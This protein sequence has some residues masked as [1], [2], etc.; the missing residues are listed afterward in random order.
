MTNLASTPVSVETENLLR[1]KN[2]ET[3]RGDVLKLLV[4]RS[5]IKVIL[6][7][8]ALGVENIFSDSHCAILLVSDDGKQLRV[9]AAPS[10]PDGFAKALDGIGIEIGSGTC[11][12]AA[13]TGNRVVAA[14]IG[15]NPFWEKFRHIAQAAGYASCC[16]DPVF[17]DENQV[18]GTFEIYKSGPGTPDPFEL[19]AIEYATSL[20]SISIERDRTQRE[21]IRHRTHL[22]HL[23]AERSEAVIKL[24]EELR[25]TVRRA[26]RSN[27]AKSNFL[28][29]MSHEI[30]TPLNAIIPVARLLGETDLSEEQS[31]Y[32]RTIQH[33][34][35][36]LLEILNQLLDWSRIENGKINLTEEAFD[37]SK[38][39]EEVCDIY[40]LSAL[41]KGLALSLDIPEAISNRFIGDRARVRQILSNLV[42]N[43]I[44]F[45][46]RGFVEIRCMIVSQSENSASVEFSVID[47]GRGIRPEDQA[48]V[49][50]KFEQTQKGI[51]Q[52]L[53]GTGLGLAI[54]KA[55]AE[56]MHGRIELNSTFGKGSTFTLA[57]E[58]KK[59]TGAGLNKNPAEAK[60]SA[61]QPH[62]T[63]RS[64]LLADDN[65]VNTAIIKTMLARMGH[66]VRIAVNGIAAVDLARTRQFDLIL[67][68]IN[69]PEMDG[70]EAAQIIR[71]FPDPRGNVPIL[72]LTAGL[73][74]DEVRKC[75]EA[76]MN[77]VL[78]K[79]I[80]IDD[81]SAALDKHCT[82]R[83]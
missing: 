61:A 17:G 75:H 41:E 27:K 32:V 36:A 5:P 65:P 18:I 8:I 67:M 50:E 59:D 3:L 53:A 33:A 29:M 56:A 26:N 24:N 79:P 70:I 76:G 52:G 78:P 34:G 45:T 7:F 83:Q 2:L 66:N 46:S 73:M 60:I 19:Q 6:N 15:S 80:S 69:M 47:T 38:L 43:A 31:E 35:T 55:L 48:R 62:L 77:A 10:L 64:I 12:T 40:R 51:A 13:A 20:A 22:E 54:S 37:L 23:V 11:G 72:A 28:A 25:Q 39:L 68:D 58:L 9:G 81:L 1:I 74:P 30:R 44:K 42:S 49:F 16:S 21:L 14:D 4:E 57:L 82:D 63:A 71:N